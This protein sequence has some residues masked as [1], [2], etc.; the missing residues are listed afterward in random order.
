[1]IS[2]FAYSFNFRGLRSRS[3]DKS[4]PLNLERNQGL[5]VSWVELTLQLIRTPN[6]IQIPGL[7]GLIRIESI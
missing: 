3:T 5:V 4:Q 1:M 7:N 6:D 2:S